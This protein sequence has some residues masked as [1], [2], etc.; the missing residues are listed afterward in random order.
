MAP[1]P[2]ITITP[3]H[4]ANTYRDTIIDIA[5][6]TITFALMAAMIALGT[7]VWRRRC[8]EGACDVCLARH[9]SN[10]SS[11]DDDMEDNG[12]VWEPKDVAGKKD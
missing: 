11:R 3:K 4:Q 7:Y 12:L 9:R 1:V 6:L 2:V 10:A 8:R 5:A